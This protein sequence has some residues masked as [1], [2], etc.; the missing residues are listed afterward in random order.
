MLLEQHIM[1]E[2]GRRM[3]TEKR[4]LT[5][6]TGKDQTEP[7]CTKVKPS[8]EV[9]MTFPLIIIL[10]RTLGSGDLTF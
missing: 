2:C 8:A 4:M 9:F 5:T 6:N 7:V 3:L 10:K 1:Q